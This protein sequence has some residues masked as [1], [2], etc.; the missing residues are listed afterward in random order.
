MTL[1]PAL[2]VGL[3]AALPHFA[4][5]RWPRRLAWLAGGAGALGFLWLI[6]KQVAAID[7]PSQFITLGLAERVVMTQ[8]LFLA[9]WLALRRATDW[10]SLWAKAGMAATALALF[11]MFWFDLGVFN[12]L[13]VP[14]SL[15]PIPVANLGTIHLGLTAFWL[16]Q[17]A[18]SRVVA[19]A[20]GQLPKLSEIASLVMMA[21]T[22]SVVDFAALPP[23]ICM[24]ASVL[25]STTRA[26]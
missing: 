6:A 24:T 20:H 25:F 7:S 15:G 19:S 23:R 13:Y 14:Q 1:L 21:L 26:D 3:I 2:L 4:L 8:L 17:M 18:R 9:G 11:R 12:P 10:S 16:W 5:G 22:V